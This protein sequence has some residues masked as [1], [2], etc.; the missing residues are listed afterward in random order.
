M[1]KFASYLKFNFCMKKHIALKFVLFQIIAQM[2]FDLSFFCSEDV[3][4]YKK[5]LCSQ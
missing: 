3:E 4:I 5:Q 2:F 1:G